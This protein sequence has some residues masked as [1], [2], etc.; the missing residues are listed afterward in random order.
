MI[1]LTRNLN[2]RRY[3][4][5]S[6][7]DALKKVVYRKNFLENPQA[8]ET[9]TSWGFWREGETE[10][11]SR[12]YKTRSQKATGRKQKLLFKERIGLR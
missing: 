5:V 4:S 2:S 11:V 6:F 9:L 7:V 8:A 12:H 1:T 10:A 3:H